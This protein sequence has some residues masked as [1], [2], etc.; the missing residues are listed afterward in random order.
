MPVYEKTGNQIVVKIGEIAH[1]MEEDHYIQWIALVSERQTTRIRLL[2]EEPSEV[3]FDYI[4]NSV[5]Y[6]YCNKHGLWK[7]EV[8]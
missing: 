1:P 2:P 6:V 8:V 7:K 3:K 5:I 4:P